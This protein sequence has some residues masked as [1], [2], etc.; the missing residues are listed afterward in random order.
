MNWKD[1]S[2]GKKI[3]VGFGVTLILASVIASLSITGIGDIVFNASQVI[4]GNKLD[5]NLA[6]KEV[7][8]LNWANEINALLTDEKVTTLMVETDD[9]KCG[10]GLWLYGEGRKEAEAMVPS[11]APLLKEI[12]EPHRKLHESAIDIG[13]HFKQADVQLPGFLAIKEVEHHLWVGEIDKLFMENLPGL[14]VETDDHKCALGMWLHGEGAKKAV[15]GKPELAR[16]MD[17]LKEPHRKLHQSAVEIQKVYK[18]VHPGLRNILKDRLDDHRRWAA[19]VSQ[20]IIEGKQNLGV[21]TDPAKC[22][23]GKFLASEEAVEWMKG[24]PQLKDALEAS[25]EPHNLL[26]LSAIEIEK[27]MV[28]GNR[29]GAEQIFI[30]QTL[31]TLEAVGRYFREAINAETVLNKAQAD[32]IAVYESNTRPALAET[33]DALHK[34]EAEAEHL[35]EGAAEANRIYAAESMP[36]LHATQKLLN[37]TREEARKHIMTDQVMLDAAQ[38]TKR[39]VTIVAIAAVV[40]GI[41]LAFFIARGII[42]VL[43]RISNQMDEGSDQ[44][45]SAS[46]Q[47]SQASQSL[48]EGS[49]EQAAS[50]EETSSSLEEMSSMTKQNAENAHQADTLMKESNQVVGQ[51][52]GSM[53]NLTTQMEEISKAS[54]ETQKIIKTIDEVAFQTNLLALNAAV[55]AARAGEAGAGFA[56]VADEVRNLAL[57]AAEAAKNTA[58]L[59]EGTVKKVADGSD[60]VS[61]TSGAFKQVSESSQKVGEL[62]GEIA[63]ASNE[64]AQGIDQVNTAVA[65][66]DKVTQQNA[67]NAEESAS[68]AEEMNAQAQQMKV[69]VAELMKLVGGSGKKEGGSAESG[70]PTSLTHSTQAFAAPTKKSKG[71]QAAVQQTKEVSPEQMIPMD[72]GDFKDF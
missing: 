50:I 34:L 28:A 30:T 22:A 21:E 64:Q 52:N 12:E 69:S 39:N 24:F 23:F 31:P 60:L 65:D 19:Q 59:I 49:S 53:E 38:G 61:K 3:A 25:K 48:A 42:T 11:L 18:Q 8:H 54:E 43:R 14:E 66:M 35:L 7:D 15:E 40:I 68:A 67:A 58:E 44:V 17:A 37:E 47:V 56:V 1:M 33:A 27:A 10:F 46:G 36:A 41:F 26:H 57:R 55:E 16:L 29:S 13:K 45:A 51:A 5:G 72:D 4:D 20:G 2:F 32:A 70:A 63:A 71:R 62:V 6:Q 9:H